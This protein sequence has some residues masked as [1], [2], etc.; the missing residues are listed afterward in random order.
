MVT[1]VTGRVNNGGVLIA[2]LRFS[3]M[4]ILY[5]F[6]E[7]INILLKQSSLRLSFVKLLNY[8]TAHKCFD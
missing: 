7:N 8:Y 6:Y 4:T 2:G 1:N 5:I 3:Y